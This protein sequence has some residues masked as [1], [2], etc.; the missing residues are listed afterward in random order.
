VLTS[1]LGSG[2]VILDTHIWVWASNGSEKFK[3]TAS[4]GIERAAEDRRLFASAASVWE[5][6]LK[7]QK[8]DVLVSGD[9]RSWVREQRRYPGVRVLPIT[10]S[11]IVEATGLPEWIRKSDKQLHKD[12]SDRFIVAEARRQNA[13][14]VTCDL[15]IIDYARKGHVLVFD[16][17]R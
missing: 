8:G 13:V 16:A 6:A 10:S 3:K 17:R 14:L 1:D 2:P 15:L 4:H 9:L 12:P 5:I 11:T 7:A